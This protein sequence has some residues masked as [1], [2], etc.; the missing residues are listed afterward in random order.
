MCRIVSG[1]LIGQTNDYFICNTCNNFCKSKTLKHSQKLLIPIRRRRNP[2]YPNPSSRPLSLL[3]L[4]HRPR[5]RPPLRP[6]RPPPPPLIP[7]KCVP[8]LPTIWHV[9]SGSLL[10]GVFYVVMDP[11]STKYCRR[12][13]KEERKKKYP[14][15]HISNQSVLCIG[16]KVLVKD[17]QH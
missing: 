6:S 13:K 15:P 2:N 8:L 9:C 5:C 3:L 10:L 17:E 14:S 12:R 16:P 7:T 11:P 1:R 4:H